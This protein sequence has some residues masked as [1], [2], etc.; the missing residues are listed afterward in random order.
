MVFTEDGF[1]MTRDFDGWEQIY[2]QPFDG[3]QYIKLTEGRNWGTR[4]L[5]LDEAR[6]V[7]FFTSRAEISTRYDVYRLDLKKRTT[8]RSPSATTTSRQFRF[9][10]TTSTMLPRYPMSP[11]L[12]RLSL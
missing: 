9:H 11:L 3:S 1:Y 5:K 2:F 10:P 8:E 7:L 4:I 6:G 12:P